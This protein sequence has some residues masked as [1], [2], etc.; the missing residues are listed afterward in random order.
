MM[1]G[2]ILPADSPL[3]QFEIQRYADGFVDDN[4]PCPVW[5][6]ARHPLKPGVGG[7]ACGCSGPFYPIRKFPEGR[8][9]KTIEG[10]TPS[11]CLCMG[12][13]VE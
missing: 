5:V 10:Y 12:R 9:A 11:V 3:V 13:F 7:I 2:M 6:D 4:L 1:T 8:E